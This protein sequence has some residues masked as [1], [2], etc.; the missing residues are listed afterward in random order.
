MTSVHICEEPSG[1]SIDW[2][3]LIYLPI[4]QTDRRIPSFVQASFLK[5]HNSRESGTYSRERVSTGKL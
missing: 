5:C 2:Y 3:V 1:R 4:Y